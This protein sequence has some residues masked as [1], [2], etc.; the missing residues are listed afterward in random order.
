MNTVTPLH[1]WHKL[2]APPRPFHPSS[3]LV[4]LPQGPGPYLPR[5]RGGRILQGAVPLALEQWKEQREAEEAREGMGTPTEGNQ[6]PL[7]AAPS[8]DKN[9]KPKSRLFSAVHFVSRPTTSFHPFQP[10]FC[11]EKQNKTK[12]KALLHVL[13]PSF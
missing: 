13:G 7:K 1:A 9:L 5:G 4:F 10:P 11:K 2:A 8:Y 12:H 3:P 6:N